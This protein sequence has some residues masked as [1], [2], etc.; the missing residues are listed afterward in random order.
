[1]AIFTTLIMAGTYLFKITDYLVQG[2]SIWQI[3]ELTAL[4]LPG[5]L[6]KTF[7]MATLLAALLAFGQLSGNSEITAL[8]AGGASVMRMMRPVAIFGLG[9][10]LLA[11][12]FN[13]VLVPRAAIRA[14]AMQAEI[15]RTIE[16]VGHRPVF[17]PIYEGSRLAAMMVAKDFSLRNGTL[18]GATI[19][20][21]DDA[22]NVV[23]YLFAPRLRFVNEREWRIDDG[24]E[25]VSPDART[26]VVVQRD[27]WP[28]AVPALRDRPEDIFARQVTDL[29][30]YSMAMIGEQIA[31]ARRDRQFDPSQL[32]NLEFGY[33]NKI[34]V[35]MAAFVFALLGAP[36]AIRSHR[37]T[38]A[39]GFWL[40]VIIIFSYMLLANMMSI[41]ARGG[42]LPPALA[43]FSPLV[44]G[45]VA[46][47]Y[48]IHRKNM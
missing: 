19:V 12:G 17:Q 4:L 13:E 35:P 21:Y 1:M 38:A 23:M 42:K 5:I 32:A 18:T 45:V 16:K 39:A 31:K 9:A 41:Y 24:A 25:M 3:L 29:D 46:A 28:D 40:S 8:R 2:I 14:A 22:G 15:A 34:A 11:F 44:I 33:W 10:S 48:T 26:R 20:A 30:S 27:V 6:A 37:A 47:I 36:L 7:A 43:S